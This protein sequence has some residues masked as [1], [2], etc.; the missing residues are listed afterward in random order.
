MRASDSFTTTI[1]VYLDKA[2]STDSLFAES[3]KKSTKNITD[4]ITYILN[5]VKASGI[6]GYDDSE[7]YGM[8]VHYYDEDDI[9][10]GSPVNGNVVVN[11]SIPAASKKAAAPAVN[12]TATEAAA[13]K[14]KVS[15]KKE[16]VNQP[17]LF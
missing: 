12:V 16:I 8:A 3:Y 14:K 2:A 13:P 11:H 1:K 7:I 9:K 6:M 4:C 17:S 5:T 15:P 10:V